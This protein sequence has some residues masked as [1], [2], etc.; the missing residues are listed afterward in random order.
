MMRPNN[1]HAVDAPVAS[2]FHVVH[3]WRRAPD[4]QRYLFHAR[5]ESVTWQSK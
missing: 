2:L 4:V 3:H 1:A 5:D